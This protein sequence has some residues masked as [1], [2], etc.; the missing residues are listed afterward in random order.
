MARRAPGW[1][2]LADI[3]E[4]ERTPVDMRLP[5]TDS[6]AAI[7]HGAALDPDKAALLW[8]PGGRA[9]D[10]PQVVSYRTLLERVTQ[11]ANMLHALGIG[12][13]DVISLLLP[14][15]PQTQYALWGAE[16]A[17]IANPVNPFLETSQIVEILRAART[18]V[19]I[20]CA[21]TLFPDSW[22]KIEAVR[23]EL[24]EL[25]AVLCIGGAGEVADALDFDAAISDQPSDRLVSGRIIAP[26]DVAAYFHTGGT[27]GMPKLAKHTHRG[28][29]LQAWALATALDPDPDNTVI[30][31]LPMFHVSGTTVTSLPA[32]LHGMT[33]VLL[34]PLGYRSPEVVRDLLPN[35]ARLRVTALIGVPTV[36]N[37]LLTG[38]PEGLDLFRFRWGL[39]GGAPLSDE[40][41]RAAGRDLGLRIVEGWGMTETHGFATITPLEGEQRI[42]SA[43][44]RAPYLEM[45]VA[46]REPDGTVSR[47][48][49]V[50]E[51]GSI[52]IRGPQVFAG[53]VQAAYDRQAFAGDGWFDTGDL[54]RIDANGYVWLTGRSKD[55]IIRGGHNIDPAVIEEVLY[56]HPAVDLAAAVGRPDARVGEMPVAYVQLKPGRTVALA[57]LQDFVRARIGERAAIPA[58]ILIIEPMPMTAVGK[59]Y[60]PALREDATRRTIE[61]VLRPVA[62]DSVQVAVAVEPHRVHGTLA[63]VRV[64]APD[65]AR[66]AAAE[67]ACRELLA[68]FAIR[69]EIR[70]A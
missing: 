4:V 6:Y 24:R 52:L 51:I 20:G 2:T 25:T 44:L 54:G 17:G 42:G 58:E 19:L 59:I 16:A 39:I 60:K 64:S 48:C 5:A 69:H 66:A 56:Q 8:L 57:E 45:R 46:V 9:E 30:H 32:F 11:S 53:Y 70:R 68:G 12:P 34:G 38:S 26:D 61:Q 67:R 22:P 40:L 37:L 65:H 36:V 18:K 49:A 13:H 43:G 28:Q 14:I 21:P 1:R 15:L 50:D 10:V 3:M 35:M 62:S 29:V 7:A 23:R 55:L 63:S 47:D 31:G 27:T 41:V 33:L